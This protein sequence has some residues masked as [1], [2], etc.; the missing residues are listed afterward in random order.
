M[1]LASLIGEFGLEEEIVARDQT[2]RISGCQPLTDCGFK[3]VAALVGRIDGA[4]ARTDGEFSESSRAIFF[5]GG[6]LEEA[7]GG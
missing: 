4:K 6:A 2:C 5:P 3:V 1:V 7:G